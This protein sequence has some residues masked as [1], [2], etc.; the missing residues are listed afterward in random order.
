MKTDAH[1]FMANVRAALGRDTTVPPSQPPPV[2]DESIVR[3]ASHDDDLL[4]MF[5]QR[6]EEV[7]RPVERGKDCRGCGRRPLR[8]ASASPR[9][10]HDRSWSQEYD[11]RRTA[12]TA[13][14]V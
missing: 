11:A 9:K 3:L 1:A 7:A 8:A 10:Q 12:G 6:A 13:A 2:V 14:N 4:A 5:Q